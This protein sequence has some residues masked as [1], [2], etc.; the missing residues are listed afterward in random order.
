MG[1]KVT[2]G[3]GDTA[4]ITGYSV[5]EDSTPINPADSNGG[6]G[7][8]NVNVPDNAVKGSWRDV[9]K[10][11]RA[12]LVPNPSFEYFTNDWDAQSGVTLTRIT[13]DSFVN[14]ACASVTVD[15]S[16]I[17]QGIYTNPRLA[18]RKNEV[19][20]A[21]A[22]VKGE[23]GKILNIS[24]QSYTS[25]GSAISTSDSLSL[26]ANGSWQRIFVSRK[27]ESNAATAI[28]Y[29][30]NVNAV[31]HTF[32]VD[33]VMLEESVSL[34]EYFDGNFGKVDDKNYYWA[35]ATN[36][37]ASVERD[38][39][40]AVNNIVNPSM[41]TANTP[42]TFLRSN[43]IPNPS[44]AVN[45]DGWDGIIFHRNLPGV[46]G[47]NGYITINHSSVAF[48][49]LIPV[50]P[51]RSYNFSVYLRKAT[52]DRTNIELLFLSES[53]DVVTSEAIN[54]PSGAPDNEWVRLN[55]SA[56]TTST[57]PA[58]YL[59]IVISGLGQVDVDN[60]LLE[61]DTTSASN[62]FDGNT[63]DTADIVYAWLGDSN[64]SVS[65]MSTSQVIVR[66]NLDTN[67]GLETQFGTA[68]QA[69]ENPNP[70]MEFS[71]DSIRSVSEYNLVTNPSFET[72]SGTLN[73]IDLNSC[74]NPGLRVDGTGWSTSS[75]GPVA[76]GA[77]VTGNFAS[78][79]TVA[80][81]RNTV[82][83]A[84]TGQTDIRYGIS[85]TTHI[86]VAA[87]IRY[88]ASGYVRANINLT[89]TRIY[90]IWY[91]SAGAQLGEVNIPTQPALSANTYRRMEITGIAPTGAVR[92]LILLRGYG[93][94]AVGN[95]FDGGAVQMDTN[96]DAATTWFDG[97]LAA[98]GGLQHAW[99]GP[100]N[101]SRSIRQGFL[102]P[103][104]QNTGGGK[105]WQS[106]L[107][108]QNGVD[109][110][111]VTGLLQQ[112]NTAV[113]RFTVDNVGLPNQTYTAKI[114]ARCATGLTVVTKGN[115]EI[116]EVGGTILAILVP[117]GTTIT[118]TPQ[119]FTV[120]FTAPALPS[121]A[122]AFKLRGGTSSSDIIYYDKAFLAFGNYTGEYFDGSTTPAG[123]DPELSV[124]WE[125]TAHAS[126]S[127][128][129]AIQPDDYVAG[130]S[131]LVQSSQWF[132]GGSK[133]LRI[134][135][136]PR[137][138]G[139]NNTFANLSSANLIDDGTV[140]PGVKYTFLG[141]VRL[142]EAQTN[143]R[144]DSARNAVF[145]ALRPSGTEV[146]P[147]GSTPPN[148][149]GVYEI[150]GT[151]TVPED[152]LSAQI[153][154]YNGDEYNGA[155]VWWDNAMVI[156]GE[157]YG[158]Y[159][160]GSTPSTSEMVYIQSG[161]FS[162]L[163]VLKPKN[164][165][166]QTVQLLPLYTYSTYVLRTATEKYSGTY[167]MKCS[168][169]GDGAYVYSRS[170]YTVTPS[171]QYTLSAK[172]KGDS[173]KLFAFGYLS[174]SGIVESSTQTLTGSWEE[175]SYT[176]TTG[177]TQ[178]VIEE[179]FFI[180]KSAGVL[181]EF[182][183]DEILFEE[184]EEA[185]SWFDGD[186]AE[187]EDFTYQWVGAPNESKSIQVSP[188][189]A[190]YTAN[191]CRAIWSS[192]WAAL[193][194]KSLRIT[195]NTD[196]TDSFVEIFTS[197]SESVGKTFTVLG[198]S[199][200]SEA[201]TSPQAV[202]R[203]IAVYVNDTLAETSTQA[204]NAAGVTEHS[205]IFTVPEDATSLS[206]RLYN[207]ADEFG[208]DVWWDKVALVE[209]EWTEGYFDGNTTDYEYNSYA[210]TGEVN[211]STSEKRIRSQETNYN[212]F[213]NDFIDLEDGAQ[214]TT[215]GT[216]NSVNNTD[217]LLSIS[218]DSRLS[219]FVAERSVQPYNGTLG[220]AFTYYLSLVGITSGFSIDPSIASRSVRFPGWYGDMW[221]AM[222]QMVAAQRVEIAL[223]SDNIVLRPIRTRIAENVRDISQS[224]SVQ[225]AQLAEKI[226]VYQYNNTVVNDAVIYPKPVWDW[227][228]ST[229]RYQFIYGT[230]ISEPQVYQVDADETITVDI[231]L[232][233]SIYSGTIK[234]PYAINALDLTLTG[235]AYL[236]TDSVY[237]IIDKE[238]RP[239]TAA[240]WNAG[241]G[242]VSVKVK[243]DTK[244]LEVK[245]KGAKDFDRAPFRLARASADEVYSAL[246]FV[247]DGIVS[248]KELLSFPTG[249][250]I[251]K[252]GQEVGIT[253][254]N[255][256]IDSTDEAYTA[257]A[258]V[259]AKYAHPQQT[260]NVSTT[261]INRSDTSQNFRY[262]TFDEF[263]ASYNSGETFADFSTAVGS[264]TFTQFDAGWAA[265]TID[266][267]ENQAF[268]NVNGARVLL[269]QAWY[270]IRN[271]TITESSV[272][273]S[274]ETDTTIEDFNDDNPYLTF[275]E[276]NNRF[277]GKKFEDYAL[278]PLWQ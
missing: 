93:T 216:I 35:G 102:I 16:V 66:E 36:A 81:W 192:E 104:Q 269:N 144:P 56:N 60:I 150:R 40:L 48:G 39:I 72:N 61:A 160:D 169:S 191:Y 77:R 135:P 213:L 230:L 76:T 141:T 47:K 179:I 251:A 114:T 115:L 244:T 106:T 166:V 165:F 276:F 202:S 64:N 173:G 256:F 31:A 278:A 229:K 178:N 91:N 4:N 277:S 13:T 54:F 228:S 263:A 131:N 82:T 137:V 71:S 212:L 214:G 167:S 146:T 152:S 168:L 254:D 127:T 204:D 231:P 249:A 50:A 79:G 139:G 198:T 201:L 84:G 186:T 98:T 123:L 222:K 189:V 33:A 242:S 92:A 174:D 145:V 224:S 103:T 32:L 211:Y 99:E 43:L 18:V 188:T 217:G 2:V 63:E 194:T 253:I 240:Q 220:G 257:A 3:S 74:Y 239:Y 207:G 78:V 97:G 262:P 126:R 183:V 245:I 247:A 111:A 26:T 101:A 236:G 130:N 87:G 225:N 205:I 250:P 73:T 134:I 121:T 38:G 187:F 272:S 155:D 113:V 151:F 215:R 157:Y 122:F 118:S 5:Q 264:E 46:D 15:G 28:I 149:A 89:G 21:S 164:W 227:S 181:N 27:M 37:S 105:G 142:T 42:N 265:E 203:Q 85:G 260:I 1:V 116:E 83:T 270:R 29:V 195:P 34:T 143:P 235:G 237:C 112:T 52:I 119:E 252:V 125:G 140:I 267:F 163:Q 133:S 129:G 258:I 170:A 248:E 22:W 53:L 159:F 90:I 51:D 177:S 243:E 20:T 158:E 69:N 88:T 175:F 232:N 184:A 124:A 161:S 94:F 221:A 182:Y 206:V 153:R 218:A 59:R 275:R 274:A 209:G 197:V 273:Y 62:Y 24:L 154:L 107:F 223:V 185:G 70:G 100:A 17:R 176:F 259:A 7:Q 147:L 233:T 10:I 226:Q 238:G 208:G 196:S 255:P 132:E 45:A 8:I 75:S 96:A 44:F 156:K 108:P 210:W 180:N 11:L 95:R 30:R 128:I 117:D 68:Q 49:D 172:V 193:G 171:T 136:G 148:A 271:A 110:F 246:Y 219:V 14:S 19:Y 266:T 6:V 23:V 9:T 80:Y 67:P 199:R 190:G 25:A 241:K 86:P 162:F 57:T 120:N 55:V 109:S 138:S 65:I 12:N 41:E 58:V 268:G 234:Q 261:A 200:L